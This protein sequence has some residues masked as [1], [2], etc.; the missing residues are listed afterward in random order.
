ML[1][2]K[3]KLRF[4]EKE[5]LTEIVFFM[6]EHNMLF[7]I[8]FERKAVF[9]FWENIQVINDFRANEANEA[10]MWWFQTSNDA[11][12]HITE[13]TLETKKAS[14]DGSAKIG[15]HDFR[16]AYKT[17][18]PSLEQKWLAWT[19]IFNPGE[20]MESREVI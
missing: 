3:E 13:A 17:I 12:D 19:M 7:N 1:S 5:T 14:A 11:Y 18:S 16:S 2:W 6:Q 15:V 4:Y 20:K 10:A 8:L 9:A